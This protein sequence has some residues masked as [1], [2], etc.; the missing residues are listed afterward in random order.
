MESAA[1]DP[2]PRTAPLVFVGGTGRSGTHVI[3]KLLGRS[4]DLAPIPLECRFHVEDRGFPGLL[5]GD[6]SKRRFMRRMRGFWW[7]GFQRTRFRGLY[8]FV[9]RER[10]D[11]ALAAF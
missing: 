2:R 9:D 11:A 5:S 1:S 6:V 3:G 4:A 8:R 7:K 10:F